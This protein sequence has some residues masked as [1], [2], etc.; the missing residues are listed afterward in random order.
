MR[1]E[2][3]SKSYGSVR[4]VDDLSLSIELGESIALLGPSGCG[5]TT[6]L[7]L[8]A[9]FLV[10]DSG[11]IRIAGRDVTGIPPNKRRLGMVFQSYALFPHMTV[12]DNVAFGLRLRRVKKE[13]QQQ[14][15]EEALEMVRLGGLS[16][17]YP[18]QL[19]GGQQQ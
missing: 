15:V 10:P 18:R 8:V 2:G 9:G 7:N 12:G 19:S 5:K 17:R 14:R 11:V 1:L 13:E 6:T 3:V 4:A 16:D